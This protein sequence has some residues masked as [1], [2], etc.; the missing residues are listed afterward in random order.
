V[1]SNKQQKTALNLYSSHYENPIE[2]ETSMKRKVFTRKPSN[3]PSITSDKRKKNAAE[4]V[5]TKT[6]VE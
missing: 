2:I 1:N 6:I 5:T 4:A 3:N